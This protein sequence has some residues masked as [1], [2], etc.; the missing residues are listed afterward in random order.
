M[1]DTVVVVEAKPFTVRLDARLLARIDKL[2]RRRAE[3]GEPT[4]TRAGAIR[5]LLEKA[6]AAQEKRK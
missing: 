6:L 1:Y 4:L 3:L 2:I 5:W